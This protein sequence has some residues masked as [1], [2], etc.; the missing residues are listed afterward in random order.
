MIDCILFIGCPG[1]GKTTQSLLLKQFIKCSDFSIGAF[2]RSEVAKKTDFGIEL[3]KMIEEKF[4]LSNDVVFQIIKE[5]LNDY[6]TLYLLDPFPATVEQSSLLSEFA[7]FGFSIKGCIEFMIS[8]DT[9]ICRLTNRVMCSKCNY[10]LLPNSLCKCGGTETY[11]RQDDDVSIITRRVKEYFN[12]REQII[13]NIKSNI[14][15]FAILD[16]D[17]KPDLVTE[18]LL[19][20]INKFN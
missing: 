9:A 13:E 16:A 12:T 14:S 6:N 19:K 7:K 4:F 1:S 3:K 2:Y 20:I 10:S 18:G 17:K 5:N 15:N 8:K 11:L